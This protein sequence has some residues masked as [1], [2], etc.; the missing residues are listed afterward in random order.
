[1]VGLHRAEVEARRVRRQRPEPEA[2]ATRRSPT[3]NLSLGCP[4][5]SSLSR[6]L[7]RPE[8]RAG[9]S[10]RKQIA[11]P[12][13]TLLER[14]PDPTLLYRNTFTRYDTLKAFALADAVIHRD[15]NPAWLHPGIRTEINAPVEPCVRAIGPHLEGGH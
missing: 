9:S 14:R 7:Q 10:R 1:M 8:E 2:G 12:A 3:R 15:S 13:C 11:I 5:V 6:R 4:V